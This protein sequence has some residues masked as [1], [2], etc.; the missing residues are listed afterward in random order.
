MPKKVYISDNLLKMRDHLKRNYEKYHQEKDSDALLTGESPVE[1]TDFPAS[2]E[3]NAATSVPGI[4]NMKNDSGHLRYMPSIRRS[5][6]I[7]TKEDRERRELEG[8]V[9]RDLHIVENESGILRVKLAEAEHYQKFLAHKHAELMNAAESN[10]CDSLPRI[11]A[12]YA[13]ANGRWEAYR[14]KSSVPQMPMSSDQVVSNDR[15]GVFLIAGA[16]FAGC[17]IVSAVL[18]VIF[19]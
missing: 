14:E 12:E 2:A 6:H 15:F 9:I 5:N 13:A 18:L 1:N 19:T 10:N 8:K 3:N 17:V 4:G 11:Q 7:D 16:I